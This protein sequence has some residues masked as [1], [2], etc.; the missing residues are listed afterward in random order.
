MSVYF[1]IFVWYGV[2]NWCEPD[3]T[4][5]AEKLMISKDQSKKTTAVLQPLLLFPS[6]C[7]VTHISAVPRSREIMYKTEKCQKL[8]VKPCFSM[9]SYVIWPVQFG[10]SHEI[11]PFNMLHTTF[12]CGINYHDT[13]THYYYLLLLLSIVEK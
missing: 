11:F 13:S 4:L 6:K 1:S 10:Y 12:F 2:Q 9:D 8:M 3:I 7:S 5:L